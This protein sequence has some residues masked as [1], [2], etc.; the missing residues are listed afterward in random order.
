[1]TAPKP[2]EA[3]SAD[4]KNWPFLQHIVLPIADWWRRHAEAQ[5]N[6]AGLEGLGH[7]ELARVALD[8]GVSATDLRALAQHCS[9]AAELLDRRI[10]ALDMNPNGLARDAGAQLRDMERL[11]TMCESKGRCAHD[12]VADPDDEIWRKYCPNQEALTD[13]ARAGLKS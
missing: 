10:V 3:S 8:V 13:L 5:G 12:L 9:D 6:A 11:C 1:M 4:I 2:T 7:E